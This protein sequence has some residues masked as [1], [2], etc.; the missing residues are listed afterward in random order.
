MRCKQFTYICSV[1]NDKQKENIMRT[2]AKLD[3]K[4]E[5]AGSYIIKH[6]GEKYKACTV[7]YDGRPVEWNLLLLTYSEVLQME[8]EEWCN[9]FPTLRD[10]KN[11]FND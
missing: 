3:I 5:F 9:T 7:Q 10:L 2:L 6:D 4:R 8:T 1:N 11:A